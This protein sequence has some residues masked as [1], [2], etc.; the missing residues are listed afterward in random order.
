MRFRTLLIF[1]LGISSLGAW[2]QRYCNE[3]IDYNNRYAKFPLVKRGVYRLDSATLAKQFNLNTV[4]PKNFQVFL[5]GKEQHIYIEGEADN[6]LNSNDFIEFYY[7]G[8]PGEADSLIYTNA[9]YLSNPYLALFSDTAYAFITL[10]KTTNNL[11]YT[12]E[13]DVNP[14]SHPVG[15]YVYAEEIWA[16]AGTYNPDASFIDNS[17]SPLY[18]QAEARGAGFFNMPA[19]GNSPLFFTFNNLNLYTGSTQLPVYMQYNASGA[20]TSPQSFDHRYQAFYSDISASN[21][22][23]TDTT[24]SGVVPLKLSYT[25]SPATLG[26][27]LS[28]TFAATNSPLFTNVTNNFVLHYFKLTYPQTLNLNNRAAQQFYLDDNTQ[29][30]KVVYSFSNFSAGPRVEFFDLS[31]HRYITT[32]ATNGSVAVVVPNGMGRKNCYMVSSDSVYRV[33][34]L[35]PAG[36]N[37]YFSN[38]RNSAPAPYVIVFNGKLKSSA[39]RY[40]NYRQ[41]PQGGA[42]NVVSAD[43]ALLYEQFSYGAKNHPLAIKNFIRLLKDS[44]SAPP[45]YVLLLGKGSKGN[46]IYYSGIYAERNLIPAFG[47]PGSDL[48]YTSAL[49]NTLNPY[50]PEIPIGRIAALKDLEVDNYLEKVKQH[51]AP[52]QSTL[53]KKNVLH[54]VGGDDEILLKTLSN[55]MDH[56]KTII[57]DTL[58][59][60]NVKTF[61]KNTTSPIQNKINDS[62]FNLIKNGCSILTFFGHG[63]YSGFD[64]AIDNPDKY[65]NAGRYPFFIANSCNSGDYYFTAGSLRS[66]SENFV[67][68][69]QKGSIGFIA[70]TSFGQDGR[71]Y[72]YTVELY[73]ALTATAYGKGLGDA[74]KVAAEVADQQGIAKKLMAHDMAFH[75]DPAIRIDPG[76]L[77]DYRIENN[78]VTFD[79]KKHTDSVGVKIIYQNAGASRNKTITTRIIRYLP[80]NDSMVINVDRPAPGVADTIVRYFAI[81]L[82]R[83]LGL[84]RFV[85]KVDYLNKIVESSEQNNQTL[86][87]VDMFISGGDLYPVHPYKYAIVPKTNTITLKASTSDPFAPLTAYRLQ[88]DTSDRFIAPLQSTVITSNGG[89]I[90]WNVHLPF[91]DSTVYF[92]RVSRDSTDATAKFNWRESSFQTIGNKRGWAQAHFHQFKSNGYRFV[93]YKSLERKFSFENSKQSI[94]CRNG[95]VDKAISWAGVNYFHNTIRMAEGTPCMANGFIIAVFDSISGA[96]VRFTTNNAPVFST[97]SSCM[98]LPSMTYKNFGWVAACGPGGGNV[99]PPKWRTNMEDFLKSIPN[100]NYVLA[101]SYGYNFLGYA[102]ISTYSNSLYTEFEKIGAKTIRNVADTVPYILFGR[103]GMSA[104]QGH[105]VVGKNSTSIIELEDSI[106][107]RWKD[108]YIVSEKIGPSYGWKSLHMR[109]KSL[110]K[111]PGDTTVLKVVGFTKSGQADTL[112]VFKKDSVDLTDL[113]LYANAATY[114]YLQLVAFMRDK[115]NTTSPQL[116]RWQVIYDEAP[117]C[118]INPL[119]GF[120]NATDSIDEGGEVMFRFPIENIGHR[121]FEDTLAVTYWIEDAQR[122]KV[123]LNDKLRPAPFVSGQLIIDTIKLN[124]TRLLGSNAIWIS[125]NPLNHRH[126]QFEQ[127]QFN[128]IARYPFK[129][130]G[131]VTNPLL[132]VTFDGMRI[133]NGDIVSARPHILIS[134]KDENKFLALNDTAAFS[135]FLQA[136]NQS[137]A[138]PVYFAQGLIFTPASLPKNSCTIEYNPTLAVDGR[139]TLIVKASDRSSNSAGAEDYRIQFEVNNHPSITGVLNYPNPFTT[140]TR[141]V[142]TLTGSEIPE[143][144]TIQIMTISGKVVREITR[145][146]LGPLRIGRNITE[147]AWNGRD[148]YGDRLARGIYLYRVIT[149]LNGQEVDHSASGADKYFVKEYGKMVL[150][151]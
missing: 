15:N 100:N 76:G 151:N 93:T 102:G 69:N 96:P 83:G 28:V 7:N 58:F 90:E 24:F 73:K 121:N 34:S 33:S 62:I 75:G 19:Y 145:D 18:T 89:V 138:L 44:L 141:F 2:A 27:Q 134:L 9:G 127:H 118:A 13:T 115:V 125:V 74:V 99:F 101:Y 56:Y 22:L 148:M 110:D 10:G 26:N 21:V 38:Y 47:V 98:C 51:E 147:F 119:K 60:A 133:L 59:G 112:A 17:S 14:A 1:I 79:L 107:T 65:N 35:L 5:F 42:Y 132:D 108:G 117:E 88:L 6:K 87:G 40:A 140:S 23:L 20:G 129:V 48:M 43:V 49:T 3:W 126:Y 139:Y 143:V 41:S 111:T 16:Q 66:V 97:D 142:F 123:P 45:K 32:T 85:V 25:V 4:N 63:H 137:Q 144:F 36:T 104:G 84:N 80:N 146:E 120:T 122:N 81:D 46:E 131:D 52:N 106:K 124:S 12:L 150:I 68:A 130:K 77:P 135:V 57:T 109:V 71:L 8:R 91:A 114:P 39:A 78:N 113:S 67:L 50:L 116:K 37:G 30:S 70:T 82:N 31:N 53:W 61:R 105:E 94:A 128:N 29:G 95:I 64:Q 136:P 92:W 55:Y 72:R 11:R 54:F 86:G 149:R 103:K